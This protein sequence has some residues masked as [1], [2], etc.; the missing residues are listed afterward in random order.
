MNA[1]I[2]YY[3]I[4]MSFKPIN[5]SYFLI[6]KRMFYILVNKNIDSLL[7]GQEPIFRKY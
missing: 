4:I 5:S 6:G 7:S 1:L 3:L 2:A